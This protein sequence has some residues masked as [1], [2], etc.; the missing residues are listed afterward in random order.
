MTNGKTDTETDDAIKPT[1][2]TRTPNLS[3][4]H[5]KEGDA[6]RPS[7]QLDRHQGP[8]KDDGGRKTSFTDND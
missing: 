6:R 4:E 3:T 8:G 1:T 2:E 5:Q 7:D